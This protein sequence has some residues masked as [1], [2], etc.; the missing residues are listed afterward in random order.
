MKTAYA[1]TVS[2]TTK[3]GSTI[4]ELLHP[5]RH[6][7]GR[8]SFAEAVVEPGA[9]TLLH[10]HRASEEIYH[11]TQGAGTM[12]LGDGE[13][14]IRAGDTVLIPP[15]TRHNVTAGDGGSL[16]I[17]CA[18]NPPYSDEDTALI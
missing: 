2:F 8:M 5:A 12:R 11:V 15:G 9:T 4:R 14:A 17:L 3:D 6:G 16:K 1:E 13:F 18:C 7:P 10:L